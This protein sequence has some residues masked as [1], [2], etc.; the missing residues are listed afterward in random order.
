MTDPLI[1]S[2]K[3]MIEDIKSNK[4]PMC[5]RD[6]I[7]K[8]KDSDISI[9]P[10]EILEIIKKLTL[11]NQVFNDFL[12]NILDEGKTKNSYISPESLKLLEETSKTLDELNESCKGMA[13]KI[14]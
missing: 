14:Q 4:C 1:D 7:E 5:K 13:K 2:C 9:S 12:I 8:P 10:I 3:K 6:L 11:C